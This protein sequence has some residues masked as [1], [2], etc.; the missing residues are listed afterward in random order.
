M[1][2]KQAKTGISQKK[3]TVM[4]KQELIIPEPRETAFLQ[5]DLFL[6]KPFPPNGF[7]KPITSNCV[8]NNYSHIHIATGNQTF[9]TQ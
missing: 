5:L 9:T 3:E 6:D 2:K 4:F 1:C 8:I 7:G